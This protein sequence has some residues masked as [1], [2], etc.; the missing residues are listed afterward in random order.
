MLIVITTLILSSFGVYQYRTLKVRKTAELQQLADQII[1]R[2]TENVSKPMWEYD[3]IQ[4]V[5]A[6]MAE[7]Q[8]KNVSA[9]MVRERG[10][11]FICKIRDA[12]WRIVDALEE[13]TDAT[14]VRQQEI[15]SPV[16]GK[17]LGTVELSLTDKFVQA[18]LRQAIRN[19]AAAVVILDIVLFL[20]LAVS[21]RMLL[22]GPMARLLK[23][24]NAIAQGDF[25]QQIPI[26]QQDEIG[27]LA[28]AFRNMADA[29]ECVLQDMDRLTQAV[30]AGELGTRGNISDYAGDWQKLVLG[31]NNVIEAFTTPFN[32]T[33]T[34]MQRL[35]NGDIPEPLREVH[36]GDFDAL[37]NTLNKLIDVSL[38]T[39]QMAEA[40]AG[41]NLNATVR[42]R[43][44]QDRLMRAL[45]RMTRNLAERTAQLHGAN[46]EISALNMRLKAE[47]IQMSAEMEIARRIQTA[48]LP[49]LV[50]NIHPDFEI[51]ATMLPCT[52]VGGDYYDITFDQQGKLWLGIGDVSGH[53]VT[54]GL[55]MMMAQTAHTTI[56]SSFEADPKQIVTIINR[57]LYQN[58]HRRLNADHFMTFTAFKFLAQGRFQY[59][60]AHLSLIIY[61]HSTQTCQRIKTPGAWLNFVPDISKM[62]RNS[63]F[64][65]EIGDILVLYTDGLTEV[66]RGPDKEEMLDIWRFMKIVA[67]HGSKDIEAMRDAIMQDV[68]SWCDHDQDDDMTLVVVRR[69]N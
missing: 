55:I 53:G 15:I 44:D 13:T 66:W 52:E 16:R 64:T 33:A 1:V 68:L 18:E 48:L 24:A 62:T 20:S 23:A 10:K 38:K 35:S 54:S 69:I 59:A 19:L 27:A 31:I 63:E 46:Q 45:N 3:H 22:L 28:D 58:V 6:V 9:V 7:M 4:V 21:F 17:M 40:I 11:Q 50:K 61:R 30:Q 37:K 25:R 41:G 26:E 60:G 56:T 47:N 2:L 57:V 42:E 14:V 49:K 8:E 67:T 65:L 34:A 5:K 36:H 39:V 32:V 43:S 12:Q 29:I 51:A